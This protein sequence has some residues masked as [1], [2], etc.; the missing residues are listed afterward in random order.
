VGT[1]AW[2]MVLLL[3]VWTG[4]YPD[5][6]VRPALSDRPVPVTGIRHDGLDFGPIGYPVGPVIG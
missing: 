4:Q 2:G 5:K 6:P 3:D 1:L